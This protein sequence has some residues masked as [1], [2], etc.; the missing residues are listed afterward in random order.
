M[1]DY[2]A[3]YLYGLQCG[4]FIK[5][6]VANAIGPRVKLLQLGNPYPLKVVIR[7]KNTYAYVLEKLV[8][9]ILSG[10]SIGREWFEVSIPEARAAVRAAKADLKERETQQ[11]EWEAQALLKHKNRGM[12][13]E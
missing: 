3:P 11:R 7:E 4:E 13:V 12:H 9:Q 5:I 6:G 10:K 2:N 1:R 8:H